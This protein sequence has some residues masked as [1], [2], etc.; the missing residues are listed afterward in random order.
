MKMHKGLIE[1]LRSFL[2]VVPDGKKSA[3]CSCQ[4]CPGE[5][6]DETDAVI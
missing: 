5:I 4:F 2:N 6:S 3:S 1:E